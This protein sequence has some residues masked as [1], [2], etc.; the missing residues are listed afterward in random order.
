MNIFLSYNRQNQPFVTQIADQLRTLNV[1]TSGELF[2]DQDNLE[3]GDVWAAK[4]Q[5]A[6]VNSEVCVVFIGEQGI[7][8]WQ[9]KA[10]TTNPH[11]KIT[12]PALSSV[13]TIP[14]NALP[15][16]INYTRSKRARTGKSP[17]KAYNKQYLAWRAESLLALALDALSLAEIDIH[18]L[19]VGAET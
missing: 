6:L 1:G 3:S 9:N 7:G 2:F 18:T 13:V 4:I 14:P 12:I 19:N 11:I 10:L 8:N 16:R 15:V 17:Q 5:E